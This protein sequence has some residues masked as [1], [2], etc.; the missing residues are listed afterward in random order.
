M[1]SDSGCSHTTFHVQS[2]ATSGTSGTSARR[3]VK[4]S[5]GRGR[6]SRQAVAKQKLDAD[7][8]K[9]QEQAQAGFGVPSW[10]MYVGLYCFFNY[11]L[12]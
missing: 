8:Q 10:A 6:S 12:K 3:V 11:V 4:V 1:P 9:Q 7:M 5:G 2:D